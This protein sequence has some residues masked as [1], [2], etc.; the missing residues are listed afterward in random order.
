MEKELDKFIA[1]FW[2]KYGIKATCFTYLKENGS[3]FMAGGMDEKFNCKFTQTAII[4][5]MLETTLEKL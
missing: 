2:E 1:N 3:G 4:K 5:H